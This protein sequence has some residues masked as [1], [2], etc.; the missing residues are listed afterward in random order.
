MA[1]CLYDSHITL[2]LLSTLVY[3][4][5]SNH[6]PYH[7]TLFFYYSPYLLSLVYWSHS[8]YDVLRVLAY[9]PL[10]VGS[11]GYARFLYKCNPRTRYV[12]YIH[13]YIVGLLMK[14]PGV[15]SY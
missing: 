5:G 3:D 7:L 1:F 4:E 14:I 9:T 6:V 12:R 13:K 15:V 11:E 8:F 10:F 2:L